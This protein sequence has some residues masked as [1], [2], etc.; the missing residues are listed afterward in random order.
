MLILKQV[1][2]GFF[3]IDHSLLNLAEINFVFVCFTINKIIKQHYIIFN[4]LPRKVPFP[5]TCPSTE[6][7]FRK[8]VE[9]FVSP[10]T[11]YLILK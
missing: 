11:K 8:C 2:C 6:I 10:T 1:L 9:R 3:R 7:A 4:E 5:R